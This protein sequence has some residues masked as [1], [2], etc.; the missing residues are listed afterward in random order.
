MTN[1]FELLHNSGVE[2]QSG[3]R[4]QSRIPK[5]HSYPSSTVTSSAGQPPRE[6]Y[7]HRYWQLHCPGSGAAC[8]RERFGCMWL[9]FPCRT[10]HE[11]NGRIRHILQF[12]RR[13]P[14]AWRLKLLQS[15]PKKSSKPLTMLR[16][17]DITRP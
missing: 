2:Q 11:S 4:S 16:T 13:A 3:P 5:R 10:A 14:T 6:H 17:R 9:C 7:C 12:W 8:S 15:I 1:R